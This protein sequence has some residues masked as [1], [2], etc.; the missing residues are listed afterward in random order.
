MMLAIRRLAAPWWMSC[1]G[2][3]ELYPRGFIDK[4]TNYTF[5]SRVYVIDLLHKEFVVYSYWEVERF[6]FSLCNL[7]ERV[8][9]LITS[10]FLM[11][12]LVAPVYSSAL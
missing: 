7:F 1:G 6:D 8:Y 4:G 11:F 9:T 5:V 2:S 12:V 3:G 10:M